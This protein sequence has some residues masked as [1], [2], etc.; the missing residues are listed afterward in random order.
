YEEIVPMSEEMKTQVLTLCYE[1]YVRDEYPE[2]TVADLKI[3]YDMGNRN[4]NYVFIFSDARKYK[5]DPYRW[6]SEVVRTYTSRFM[7][8]TY[9][10]KLGY[11][12][13]DG[14]PMRV[15]NNGVVYGFSEAFEKG[16]LSEADME[17]FL[18]CRWFVTEGE[19]MQ[20]RM[21]RTLENEIME[22]Y[23]NTECNDPDYYCCKYFVVVKYYLGIYNGYAIVGLSEG[24][25]LDSIT[26]MEKITIDN[27][28]L[29]QNISNPLM[30]YKDNRLLLLEDAYNA[31]LI[32]KEDLILIAEKANSKELP[33]YNYSYL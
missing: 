28:T 32:T 26:S 16:M 24:L 3:D 5:N 13:K 1:K 8:K 6:E 23:I 17:Y 27:V 25:Q 14:R 22:C 19:R 2:Q 15:Y 9:E 4:G 33:I 7:S 29:L 30:A 31:G 11:Q 18:Q 10:Q 20:K 12:H 21:D